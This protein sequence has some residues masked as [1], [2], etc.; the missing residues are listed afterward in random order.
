M[1]EEAE[2]LRDLVNLVAP[3]RAAWLPRA[4]G[5]SR[6]GWSMATA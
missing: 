1:L 4:G 2:V 3:Q 6:S 5:G